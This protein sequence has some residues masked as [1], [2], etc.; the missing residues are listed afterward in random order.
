[1]RRS[2]S[3]L[4]RILAFFAATGILG[5]ITLGIGLMVLIPD[6]PSIESI[7]DIH[8]K[9]PLRVYTADGKMIAEFGDE[10]RIPV[11]IDEVPETLVKAILAVEDDAFYSH[12]GVD[13]VGV[14]RA[15]ITNIR[16]GQR[17]QV[18]APSPCRWHKTT[19]SVEKKPGLGR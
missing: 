19:S 6:L 16:S 5:A 2:S 13:F 3:T 15:M 7:Q 17:G 12:P 10:R 9:V 1:M 11:S 8:L 4:V 14:L 18:R